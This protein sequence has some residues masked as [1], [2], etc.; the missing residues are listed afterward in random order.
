[1]VVAN[2]TLPIFAPGTNP[3]RVP[4]PVKINC[5]LGPFVKVVP[6]AYLAGGR[7]PGFNRWIEFCLTTSNFV[8]SDVVG[9]IA[10]R[11]LTKEQA[12][13]YDAPYPSFVYKAAPRAFPSMVAAIETNNEAAWA[14]LGKFDRPFLSFAGEKDVNLGSKEMQDQLINHIPGAKGQPHERFKDAGHFIQ[15]DIGET[16][17]ERVNTFIK[18]NPRR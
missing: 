2:G 6:P 16:V 1:V 18:A 15:E 4:D 7:V 3:F 14:A 8:A 17:A 12:A 10:V 5:D 13:G 9:F 11:K